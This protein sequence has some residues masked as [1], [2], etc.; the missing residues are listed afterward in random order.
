[1]AYGENLSQLEGQLIEVKFIYE[2]GLEKLNLVKPK[3]YKQWLGNAIKTANDH[4]IKHIFF[5]RLIDDI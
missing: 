4:S 5:T 2:C 1:M 3:D